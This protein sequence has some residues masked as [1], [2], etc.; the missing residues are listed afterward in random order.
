MAFL[1]LEDEG[2]MINIVIRPDVY[3]AYC[4]A[5]RRPF[6]AIRGEVERRGPALNIVAQEVNSLDM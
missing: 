4:D 6:L 2:G 1:A 3:E 5:L